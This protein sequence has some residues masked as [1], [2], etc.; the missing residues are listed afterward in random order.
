MMKRTKILLAAF[1]MSCVLLSSIMPAYGYFTANTQSSGEVTIKGIDTD[2][3]ETLGNW[4]K[5]LTI[6][7]RPDGAP[8][9]VR[10]RGFSGDLTGELT[11][12]GEGWTAGGDG[13]Y[14]YDSL[15]MPEDPDND[16][17]G[18]SLPLTV[19][20]S[21]VFPE[22]AIQGDNVNIVVVYESVLPMDGVEGA[23]ATFQAFIS[24]GGR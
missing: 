11:Y 9:Y 3:D 20:I 4:E 17:P 5:I 15:L 18:T 12:S 16:E 14:Y 2:F 1:M 24:Q 7:N 6:K 22:G 21:K 10:A 13:W 23:Q 8:V 19:N